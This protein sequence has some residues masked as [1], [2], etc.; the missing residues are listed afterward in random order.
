MFLSYFPSDECRNL[1]EVPLSCIVMKIYGALLKKRLKLI[2]SHEEADLK[3]NFPH[4]EES[5]SSSYCCK[6]DGSL[7]TFMICVK[8]VGMCSPAMAYEDWF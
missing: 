3:V 8:L 1:F 5:W 4:R 2:L 7:F 6:R